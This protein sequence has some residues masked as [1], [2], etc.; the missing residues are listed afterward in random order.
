MVLHTVPYGGGELYGARR[1]NGIRGELQDLERRQGLR[2][3][4]DGD[5]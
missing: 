4:R 3:S 1:V 2:Q 5:I